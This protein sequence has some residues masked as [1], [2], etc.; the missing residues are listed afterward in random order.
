MPQC[1]TLLSSPAS[2][3]QTSR[4][5]ARGSLSVSRSVAVVMRDLLWIVQVSVRVEVEVLQLVFA[6]EIAG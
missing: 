1:E 4:A 2:L 3:S 5:N 6:P